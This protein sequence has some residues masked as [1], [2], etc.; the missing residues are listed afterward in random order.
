MHQMH[1]DRFESRIARAA[2]LRI[3]LALLAVV[4]LT[5]CKQ[6]TAYYR[7]KYSASRSAWQV[8][9]QTP[10][11]EKTSILIQSNFGRTTSL[12]VA[13]RT[14][15]KDLVIEVEYKIVPA[16]K[17]VGSSISSLEIL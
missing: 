5:A 4:G 10:K 6:K 17:V 12:T 8:C 13:R 2:T 1:Q 7:S 14:T 11:G 16:K 15:E 9:I 3:T